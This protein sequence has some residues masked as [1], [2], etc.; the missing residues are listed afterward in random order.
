MPLVRLKTLFPLVAL[1]SI[2]FFFWCVDRYDRAALMRF[3]RPIDHMSN[4]APVPGQAQAPSHPQIQVQPQT[5]ASSCEVDPASA[6]PLP[7]NEWL[8]AKN[9]TRAYFRPHHVSPKTE[10][11]SLEDVNTPV[12]APFVEMDRGTRLPPQYNTMPCPPIIDVDVAADYDVEETSK[13]LFGLATTVDRLERLLP[14]LL[15][16]FG[17][18]K[19]GIIVLVPPTDDDLSQQEMYFRS[20]GLDV[21]IQSSPLE[22]TARY[23]GLVEAFD[24][25]IRTVRPNTTWVSF[26]DD[27]TFFLSLPSI[28]EQL[29]LFDAT[30]KHYIGSLSEASWQVDTFGHIA[31]GGAGVFVSVPLLEVLTTVYDECQSW[32]EQPG[33]QKLGQCIERFGNTPLTIWPS[34]YQMDMQGEVDGVY[35]SGRRIDSLHHWNS[36]YTKDVVKMSTVAAAAGRKSVLRRW[37]FDQEEFINNATGQSIRTFWVLTNGYSIVKYTYLEGTPDDVINFDHTEKTWEEDPRGYEDS[38]GPL[39]PKDQEGVIKE[40]YLLKDAVVVGDNV[41]QFYTREEPDS[42]RVIEIVWLGPR[43]GGG[44]GVGGGQTKY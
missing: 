16:S 12:L 1:F 4:Q 24:E 44:A 25:H 11:G 33:D 38:L 9:Y 28:A 13:L 36:W 32:G 20:R 43:N 14:S 7:F 2:A 18:S 23:F 6:P 27:D 15:Y 26:I 41:H 21:T 8:V 29:K 10:F 34:L 42:H 22:F 39:R 17:D 40:R 5:L 37:V 35:E 3:K 30:K 19:A 31:F